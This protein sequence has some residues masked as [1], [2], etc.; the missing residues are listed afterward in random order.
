MKLTSYEIV[1]FGGL[2]LFGIIFVVASNIPSTPKLNQNLP[3]QFERS[4]DEY[5]T[6]PSSPSSSPR[7]S[8]GSQEYRGG[9]KS[10][11][12]RSLKKKRIFTKRF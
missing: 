12:K 4:S 3:G 11:K 8:F 7:S 9:K 5:F 2:A 10:K 6:P 1:A